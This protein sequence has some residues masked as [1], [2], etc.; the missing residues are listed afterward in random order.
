LV[1]TKD[2]LHNVAK[3]IFK[4]INIGYLK[5]IIIPSSVLLEYELLLKSN[6]IKSEDIIEDIVNIQEF[7]NIEEFPLSSSVLILALR[8]REEF[9]LTYFDSLHCSSAL[10]N[11]GVIIST[12]SAFEVI[13]NLVA[14]KPQDLIEKLERK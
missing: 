8:L 7:Q 3:R 12:D 9:N 13:P 5:E 1:S 10:K 6:K 2:K 4:F 11:D 14:I